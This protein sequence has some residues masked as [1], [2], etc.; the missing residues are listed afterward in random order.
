MTNITKTAALDDGAT[1]LSLLKYSIR[2]TDAEGLETVYPSEK[3]IMI[4]GSSPDADICVDDPAVSRQH[5]QLE[6]DSKG[7]RLRDLSSKNGTFLGAL[8]LNDIYLTPDATW[9]IGQ[10]RLRFEVGDERVEIRLSGRERFGDLLGSGTAM[11]ELFAILERVAPTDA[12]VLIEGESGTG[13]ELAARALHDHSG[14][15]DRPFVVFDCSAVPRDLVESELF[16]HIKGAFTGAVANRTGAFVQASGGTLFLDELGELSIDLQPKLLRVL[17]TG[18]VRPVGS[19]EVVT[20]DTRIVAATNKT[21]RREVADGNFRE[22]LYY[23]LAVIQVVLPPLR[24]RLEDL[25]MLVGH[26]LDQLGDRDGRDRLQVSFSTMEK[27]KKHQWPGNVRELKNFVER[28]AVLADGDRVETRFLKLGRPKTA[29]EA[30]EDEVAPGIMGTI[31]IDE[32]LP[33]KDAKS[34]LVEAF[35]KAYWT[36]LLERTAGNVSKAAR[37]AGVHRKSVEYIMKKLELRRSDIPGH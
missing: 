15:A 10:H 7:Y 17:D 36:R 5:C 4:I 8:R 33:F 24:K 2:V 25:P 11:R 26:F 12:T 27:L 37:V 9:T 16:G 35:E 34:R 20:C 29:T 31:K 14:R 23:R 13:K 21:L 19:T 30:A 6:V 18:R 3:R 28:A 32:D 1:L 22:D